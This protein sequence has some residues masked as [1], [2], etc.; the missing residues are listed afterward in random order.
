M[1][2]TIFY[3]SDGTGITAETIGHSVLTQFDELEFDT[4]RLPFVDD[5]KGAR[6]RRAHPQCLCDDRRGLSSSIPWSTRS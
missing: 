5:G 2:R 6:L 1:R 4:Y 3:V